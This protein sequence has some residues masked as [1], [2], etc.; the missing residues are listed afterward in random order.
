VALLA[1]AVTRLRVV[2]RRDRRDPTEAPWRFIVQHLGAGALVTVLYL[3]FARLLDGA[4]DPVTVDLRHF[5]L[6]PWSPPRIM[7]L[8]GILAFHT[9]ILWAATL[10]LTAVRSVWRIRSGAMSRRLALVTLWLLPAI[11]GA[12]ISASRGW[13]VSIAGL[14]LS[15]GLCGIAALAAQRVLVWYR[16]ATLAARILALFVTFLIPALLLYPAMNFL[17]E[18]ATRRLITTR[19]AVQAQNHPQ[20]LLDHLNEAQR[21]IDALSILPT[22][23]TGEGVPGGAPRTDSAFLVWSQTALARAPRQK[24]GQPLCLELP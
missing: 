22:L 21:E 19:Y 7:L 11:A 24:T 9:A 18:R 4:V 3:L 1:G 10:V 8:G 20:T 6:H 16:H 12:G 2:T 14:L 15:A 5:S 23:V 13:P 17:A